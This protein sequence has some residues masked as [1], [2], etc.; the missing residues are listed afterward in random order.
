MTIYKK[1]KLHRKYILKFFFT[2]NGEICE[3]KIKKEKRQ[4]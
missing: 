4:K 2:S 1:K 3:V